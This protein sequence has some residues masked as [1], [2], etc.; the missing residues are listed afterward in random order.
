MY[1]IHTL[2]S[3]IGKLFCSYHVISETYSRPI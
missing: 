1:E 3:I 2:V